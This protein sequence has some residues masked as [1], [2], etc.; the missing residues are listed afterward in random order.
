MERTRLRALEFGKTRLSRELL[1]MLV[2][3]ALGLGS[4]S[5]STACGQEDT[6]SLH[7]AIEAA[8]VRNPSVARARARAATE[9]ANRWA[10]WGGLLPS[11]SVSASLSRSDFTT[12]T[13]QNPDGTTAMLDDPIA[14]LRRSNS[15]GIGL[16]L[17]LSAETFAG[18]SVGREERT[19]AHHRLDAAEIDVIRQVKVAYFDALKQ[20]RLLD[21]ARRQLESRGQELALTRDK[22]RIAAADRSA[23]LGAEIE[24]RNAELDVLDAE[25]ALAAAIRTVRVAQ[26]IDR[27]E[28]T[29]VTL[30]DPATIPDADSLEIV[31]LLRAAQR[32]NP[33]LRALATD[34][35]AASSSLWSARASYLP[36]LDLSLNFNNSR[37]LGDDEGRF[38]FSPV[39]TNRSFVISLNWPLFNGFQRKARTAQASN[40][41]KIAEAALDE[42]RLVLEQEIR[43]IVADIQRGD[44]R[45]GV[46]T[47][48]AE[49][50][51]ERLELTREGYRVGSVDY[52][53]LQQTIEAVSQAERAVFEVRYELL[54]Q[55]AELEWRVGD[56]LSDRRR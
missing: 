1:R 18:I 12:N 25:D 56:S 11:V 42:E 34:E 46:L 35:R 19:A 51:R 53:A 28:D 13:F 50:A 55:W 24:L 26:G 44:R 14:D 52:P 40:N 32:A 7:E 17:Q 41:M 16:S 3:T 5:P 2:L 9:A 49:L 20:Q 6:L 54:K 8:L 27:M 47:K 21:V 10:D 33:D 48:N 39:N 36:T 31:A 37:Q 38:T 43:Q 23:L 4:A 45:L 30:V 15:A 22:Y 29:D